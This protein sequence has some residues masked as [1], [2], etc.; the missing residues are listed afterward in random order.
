MKD[1]LP[2][3]LYVEDEEADVLLMEY[4]LKMAQIGNPLKSVCNGAELI[5]YLTGAGVYADRE[6]FP[7]PGLVL[8]DLNLPRLSGLEVLR[9]IR[10]QAQFA[11]LPVVVYSSSEHPRDQ[12]RAKNFGANDYILKASRV[13]EMAQRIQ[14]VKE[15]WLQAAEPWNEGEE[16]A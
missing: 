3:I 1:H 2:S 16:A 7:F 8:L 13:E 4:A 9:W 14:G 15:R 11:S 5:A 12:E 10:E 6:Q